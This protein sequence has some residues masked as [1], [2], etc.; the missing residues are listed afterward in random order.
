MFW[1]NSPCCEQ[2]R[3]KPSGAGRTGSRTFLP[4][5]LYPRPTDLWCPSTPSLPP[6]PCRARYSG[7]T[8]RP[9]DTWGVNEGMDGGSIPIYWCVLGEWGDLSFCA[10]PTEASPEVED[11][12]A[13]VPKPTQTDPVPPRSTNTRPGGRTR[14]PVFPS[15][16]F[17]FSS[18]VPRAW[19]SHFLAL[20]P[21]SSY[22]PRANVLRRRCN[23]GGR[24]R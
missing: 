19:A 22:A 18:R 13:C 2:S 15:G 20:C 5:S 6:R 23:Q 17:G 12:V 11:V 1:S 4:L 10:R 9:G 21:G 14:D 3:G 8:K 24:C 16:S 7:P